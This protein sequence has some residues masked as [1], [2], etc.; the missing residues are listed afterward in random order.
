MVFT[1]FP[2]WSCNARPDLSTVRQA[3]HLLPRRVRPPGRPGY[4]GR[5]DAPP[6]HAAGAAP[7]F[8]PLAGTKHA[9]VR[10]PIGGPLGGDEYDTRAR[11][12]TGGST[13]PLAFLPSGEHPQARQR[14]RSALADLEPVR[15]QLAHC[16]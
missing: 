3:E 6:Q 4:A 16:G 14:G 2:D 9:L 13:E 8:P 10:V 5:A 11:A 15:R 12:E 7:S 1:H